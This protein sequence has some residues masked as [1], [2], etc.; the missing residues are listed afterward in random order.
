MSWIVSKRRASVVLK[1]KALAKISQ[2][3]L[4]FDFETD[5]DY[6]STL[7]RVILQM[8]QLQIL[9]EKLRPDLLT[10]ST[11]LYDVSV[12]RN[13]VSK[14]K[15]SKIC[16]ILVNYFFLSCERTCGLTDVPVSIYD[17]KTA[18]RPFDTNHNIQLS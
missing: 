13:P 3:L 4:F 5:L 9:I 17:R 18:A 7:R 11:T 12:S 8:F 15:N 1:K 6:F 10:L 16:D 2:I 14:S